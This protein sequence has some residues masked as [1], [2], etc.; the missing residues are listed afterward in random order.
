MKSK[1]GLLSLLALT[2]KLQSHFVFGDCSACKQC[3]FLY[4]IG[5]KLRTVNS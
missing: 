4:F 1:L 3:N 2:T 5:S